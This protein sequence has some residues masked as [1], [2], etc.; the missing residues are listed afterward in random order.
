MANVTCQF[1]PQTFHQIA[2]LEK[3]FESVHGGQKRNV[4]VS[5][6][7]S[8]KASNNLKESTVVKNVEKIFKTH[9][10]YLCETRCLNLE[11]M[12]MHFKDSHSKETLNTSKMMVCRV[13][14]NICGIRR[15]EFTLLSQHFTTVH[16]MQIG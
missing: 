11:L 14:C 10:C 9:V 3:H 13:V 8:V 16:N 5:D 12:Y 6:V 15:K 4:K 1:C 2:Q 7:A